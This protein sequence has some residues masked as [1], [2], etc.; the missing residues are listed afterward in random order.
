[1]IA[2]KVVTLEAGVPLPSLGQFRMGRV[3]RVLLELDLFVAG[4]A[5]VDGRVYAVAT[6]LD[7]APG[8]AVRSELIARLPKPRLLKSINRMPVIVTG[9]TG[10]AI[11][12]RDS[13]MHEI[14]AIVSTTHET[15]DFGLKLLAGCA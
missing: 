6:M 5:K 8:T 13:S 2:M 12:S 10:L 7:M 1:M 11:P 15:G 4:F 3:H 14:G 9:M